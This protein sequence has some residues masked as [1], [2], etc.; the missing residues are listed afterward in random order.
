M[1]NPICLAIVSLIYSMPQKKKMYYL[2]YCMDYL[3]NDTLF[4][5]KNLLKNRKLCRRSGGGCFLEKYRQKRERYDKCRF[6]ISIY[7]E[8]IIYKHIFLFFLIRKMR[9]RSRYR[10]SLPCCIRFL[11]CRAGQRFLC[12]AWPDFL[13]PGNSSVAARDWRHYLLFRRWNAVL[14]G[15]KRERAW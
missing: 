12:W 14:C 4:F 3:P 15:K 9:S 13:C 10:K 11:F 6:Y 5:S 2:I 8:I 1:P 7:L